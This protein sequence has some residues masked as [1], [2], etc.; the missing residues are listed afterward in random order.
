MQSGRYYFVL[1]HTSHEIALAYSP[2]PDYKQVGFERTTVL[3]AIYKVLI[4]HLP[5][6]TLLVSE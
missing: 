2:D 3:K 1:E 5:I 4:H 6:F